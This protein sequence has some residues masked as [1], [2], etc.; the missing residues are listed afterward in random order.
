MNWNYAMETLLEGAPLPVLRHMVGDDLVD[1]ALKGKA[2]ERTHEKVDYLFHEGEFLPE[3][4]WEKTGDYIEIYSAPTKKVEYTDKLFIVYRLNIVNFI[5]RATGL[6]SDETFG[7]SSNFKYNKLCNYLFSVPYLNSNIFYAPKYSEEVGLYIANNQNNTYT[8]NILITPEDR[9]MK[10]GI[11]VI[12]LLDAQGMDENGRIVFEKKLENLAASTPANPKPPYNTFPYPW[13]IEKVTWKD[14]ELDIDS[15]RLVTK[16][17]V[18]GKYRMVGKPIYIRD[19][20]FLRPDTSSSKRKERRP[21]LQTL[22]DLEAG[23]LNN[24]R[25]GLSDSKRAAL[26]RLNRDL[27]TFYAMKGCF[28]KQ[29]R[30]NYNPDCK[31]TITS[32]KYRESP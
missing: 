1:L 6:P 12:P 5:A 19:I 21:S 18:D 8:K 24:V 7:K 32:E 17:I 31:L 26:S 2:L 14:L 23:R 25:G 11:Q 27:K 28:Y 29:N 16:C 15:E 30:G 13:P 22:Y 10:N 3:K 20:P 9:G 4:S